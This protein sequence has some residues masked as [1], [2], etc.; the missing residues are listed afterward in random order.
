M[1]RIFSIAATATDDAMSDSALHE[2]AVTSAARVDAPYQ[3][4]ERPEVHLPTSGRSA[5]EL[6]G[7]VL[8]TLRKRDI[9]G[10]ASDS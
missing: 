3:P 8:E 6:A 10:V 7:L 4:P 9:L 2:T 1:S 5:D